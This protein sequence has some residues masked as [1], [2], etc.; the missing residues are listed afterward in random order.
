MLYSFKN[1]F[2]TLQKIS[3]SIDLKSCLHINFAAL[4][5]NISFSE[6]IKEEYTMLSDQLKLQLFVRVFYVFTNLIRGLIGRELINSL[7]S[8]L[9]FKMFF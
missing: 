8:S 9:E 3:R 1:R 5:I 6:L 7:N 2:D 4:H